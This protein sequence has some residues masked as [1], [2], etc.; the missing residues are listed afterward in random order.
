MRMSGKKDGKDWARS[1]QDLGIDQRLSSQ[2]QAR[3]VNRDGSFNVLRNRRGPHDVFSYNNLLQ[4]SLPRVFCV[5][6]ALFLLIN[7]VFAAVYMLCGSNTL[8]VSGP[9]PQLSPF[10]RA[11]FFSV[12]TLSTIGYGNVVPVGLDANLAVACESFVG[13]FGLSLITGI[14]F[15]RFARPATRI[16]FSERG[17]LTVGETPKLTMRLTNTSS[18]EVI[19]VEAS[20]IAAFFEPGSPSRRFRPLALERDEV[21]FLPLAWTLVHPVDDKSPFYGMDEQALKALEGE[22]ILQVTGIDQTSSQMVYA[23]TSYTTREIVWNGRFVEVH[24]RGERS[25]LLEVDLSRFDMI[26]Q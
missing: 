5:V 23:R 14:V 11:L 15:S 13:L 9:D 8:V 25:G 24:R 16:R 20:A 22:I 3:I 26:E 18:T 19:Q 12:H 21:A 6:L 1:G 10:E 2:R 4:M 17:A 7:V